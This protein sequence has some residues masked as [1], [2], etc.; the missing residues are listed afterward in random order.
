[1]TGASA[2]PGRHGFGLVLGLVM[3]VL[4][5][6]A[7]ALTAQ[8]SFSSGVADQVERDL[9]AE[10]ADRLAN[11]MVEE[12]LVR[13]AVDA[14]GGPDGR[15]HGPIFQ[16]FRGGQ[17]PAWDGQAGFRLP[18]AASDLVASQKL[19]AGFPLLRNPPPELTARVRFQRFFD[20]DGL[21][22]HDE[23]FGTLELTATV[24]YRGAAARRRAVR[25]VEFRVVHTGL[26]APFDRTPLHVT[27]PEVLVNAHAQLPDM[28]TAD[29][30]RML[31]EIATRLADL[32]P[33]LDDM[34]AKTR[35]ALDQIQSLKQ[36]AQSAIPP[37]D[38]SQLDQ[39][40]STFEALASRIETARPVAGAL[41][42]AER[43]DIDTVLSGN[44]NAAP[45]RQYGYPL[46][47]YLFVPDRS[48]SPLSLDTLDMPAITSRLVKDFRDADQTQRQAGQTFKSLVQSL[49]SSAGQ[50]GTAFV[51]ALMQLAQTERAVLD[52]FKAFESSHFEQGGDEAFARWNNFRGALAESEFR[53]LS[54]PSAGGVRIRGSKAQFAVGSAEELE[55]LLDR[56]GP[57]FQG[58]VYVDNPEGPDLVLDGTRPGSRWASFS[59]RLLLAVA[60]N[61]VLREVHRQDPA[62]DLLALIVSRDVTLGGRVEA[63]LAVGRALNR[64]PPPAA[65]VSLKGCLVMDNRAF[66]LADPPETVLAGISLERDDLAV[67]WDDRTGMRPEYESVVFGPVPAYAS[68]PRQAKP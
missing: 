45:L 39:L 30:N 5:L 38:T 10:E 14:N 47:L 40:R 24:S 29:A 68:S 57:S 16:L 26:P 4:S 25:W 51:D 41:V 27:E 52:G 42:Q 60:G 56:Y 32:P 9:R 65:A 67:S 62:R 64:M 17:N 12:A 50:A 6:L 19:L 13:I 11:S 23:R 43:R 35:Q 53:P 22:E 49:S 2:G 8:T 1:L 31:G 63:S 15:G 36:Q 44:V 34:L 48:P 46:V 61:A 55:A 54:A 33:Q 3:L 66:A 37:P 21:R 58:V 20:A 59:G 28:G 18:L 7:V